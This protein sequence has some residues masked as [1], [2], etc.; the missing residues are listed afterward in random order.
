MTTKQY[1]SQLETLD[2]KIQNKI[3]EEEQLRALATSVG[4]VGNAERV[5]SSGSGDRV[6]NIVTKI[7]D[8]Q[9]ETNTMI[10]ELLI[11]KSDVVHTI[12]AVMPIRLYE[13]LFKRYVEYK[14]MWEIADEMDYSR[15]YTN[16]LHQLAL[17][18]VRK[19]KGFEK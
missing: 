3:I 6:A 18:E 2:K 19:I 11:R 9:R 13:V 15:K 5:Q 10:D 17:E 16:T 1:L 12:E 7:V 8:V 4:A 14:P